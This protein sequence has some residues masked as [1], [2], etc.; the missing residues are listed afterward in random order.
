MKCRKCGTTAVINMRQHRL[1]LCS[2]HF[3]EWVPQQVQRAIEHFHMFAPDE[4]VLVAVSGGKDSLSL[5]DILLRL[6]YA[7]EGLYIHLGIPD[8]DYSDISQQK[9][10]HFA[11][12]HGAPFRVVNVKG[13]YGLTIPEVSS[14]KR[15]RNSCSTCG[16]VKRHILNEAACEG[17]YA[18][19][20]TGHQLDDEAAVLF[21]N[22]LHWATGYLARQAPVLPASHDGLAR[23]VK[24][25]IRLY[26]REMAA[27]ALVRGFDCIYA[28]CPY[29]KGATTLFYKELL[30]QLEESSPGAKQMFYLSFLQ[31][32][33][34][35][36]LLPAE[37]SEVKMER[38]QRCG[39]PTT[40]PDLCAFCRLWETEEFESR[41]H[42]DRE[43]AAN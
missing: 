22:A 38:C 8:G 5:W 30:N 18:V 40:V 9:V 36:R 2:E 1:S 16:L 39:Q 13:E 26:E 7:A 3:L 31:A 23:K 10:E 35:G 33:R 25:L 34:E 41:R 6:G 24:P 21:Q 42:G 32:R 28:E 27:Y 29:S 12:E 43:E 17:A 20:A 19:L 4:R 37:A 14:R 15:G 11:T